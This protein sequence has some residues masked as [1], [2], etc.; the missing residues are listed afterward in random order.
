[1]M[2]K[3]H[4]QFWDCNIEIRW[5]YFLC[6]IHFDM[7]NAGTIDRCGGCGKFKLLVYEFCIKC[8]REMSEVRSFPD[9]DAIQR[10]DREFPGDKEV[11]QFFVYILLM[12]DGKYY[13]GQT[14]NLFERIRQHRNNMSQST[15]GRDP[16]LQWF[17]AAATRSEA[18]ELEQ[19]LKHLNSNPIGRRDIRQRIATFQRLINQLDFTS[20]Q[21]PTESTATEKRRPYSGDTTM[22]TTEIST[23]RNPQPGVGD[24]P[25]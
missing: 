6:S 7:A 11:G 3:S 8:K 15:K 22:S 12:N 21:P 9:Q 5:D 24:L 20:H 16:K 18:T 25:F 23:S 17:C 2:P 1:M 19:Y 13:V 4:C 10:D 14:G